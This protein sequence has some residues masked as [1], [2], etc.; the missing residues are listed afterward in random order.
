MLATSR[1]NKKSVCWSWTVILWTK[2]RRLR[3]RSFLAWNLKTYC[4]FTRR[5]VVFFWNK[6]WAQNKTERSD[7]DTKKKLYRLWTQT[8]WIKRA[9]QSA[10]CSKVNW[11][12]FRNWSFFSCFW[13]RAGSKTLSWFVLFEQRSS[14][15]PAFRLP[16]VHKPVAVA[17]QMYSNWRVEQS[18]CFPNQVCNTCDASLVPNPVFFFRVE[19]VDK[20][21]DFRNVFVGENYVY[22][23]CGSP[24]TSSWPSISLMVNHIQVS[25]VPGK[26]RPKIL[27]S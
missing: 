16:N 19:C 21:T 13:C 25:G 8:G 17:V 27:R 6:G 10:V 14:R 24:V 2:P 4:L 11:S 1:H 3:K 7:Q 18:V 23:C 22:K 9:C 12:T 5:A 26:Y 20:Q 15:R